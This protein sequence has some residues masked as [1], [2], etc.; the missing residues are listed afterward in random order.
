MP[1]SEDKYSSC[2]KSPEERDLEFR[3]IISA[4]VADIAV[5]IMDG[6]E[7]ISSKPIYESRVL[8]D[9]V[10]IISDVAATSIE[11]DKE[12]IECIRQKKQEFSD[13]QIKEEITE[14]LKEE[15]KNLN[16][17]KSI[18]NAINPPAPTPTLSEHELRCKY[19]EANT[20]RYTKGMLLLSYDG[21]KKMCSLGADPLSISAHET[22]SQNGSAGEVVGH[23]PFVGESNK[24]IGEGCN[25]VTPVTISICFKDDSGA[26]KNCY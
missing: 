3:K 15:A 25:Q 21:Y 13:K 5:G 6:L 2:I 4:S 7:N 17:I 12:E 24:G 20:T 26:F 1:N 10:Q 18:T 16:R 8:E 23:N 14:L 22:L 11:I 9:G 19:Q